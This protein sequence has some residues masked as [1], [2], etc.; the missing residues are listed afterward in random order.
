MASDEENEETF[1]GKCGNFLF[2]NRSQSFVMPQMK[3]GK[4]SKVKEH[5]K[6]VG[7]MSR[8]RK[9][10]RYLNALH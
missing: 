3:E 8:R 2:K 10:Q 1:Q 6:H 4:K 7:V 9:S 5:W